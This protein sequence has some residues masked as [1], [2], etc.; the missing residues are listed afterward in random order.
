[1]VVSGVHNLKESMMH[2]VHLSDL[3][4]P[5]VPYSWVLVAGDA[6]LF[7]VCLALLIAY[8]TS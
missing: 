4:V 7:V 5:K 1:M 2:T 6:G 3:H 8:L